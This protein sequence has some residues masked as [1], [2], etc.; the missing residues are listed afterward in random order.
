MPHSVYTRNLGRSR[1]WRKATVR[2]LT[3]SLLE[4][5]RIETTLARAKETQRLAERLITLGKDGTLPARRQAISLLNSSRHVSRLFSQIAPRFASRPGGYTRI[6]HAGFRPGDGAR[7]ALLELVELSPEFTAPPKVKEKER[8]AKKPKEIAKPKAEQP[9]V[10][11]P[12]ADRPGLKQ[13]EAQKPQEKQDKPKGFIEGLRK[14]FKGR[15]Q[16][17]E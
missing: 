9:E 8:P 5:E 7:V 17:K 3:Q 16:E 15:G 2:S 13:L 4:H 11:K 12:K 10:P 6:V 14:F 1:S